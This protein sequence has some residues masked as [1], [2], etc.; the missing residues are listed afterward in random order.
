MLFGMTRVVVIVSTRLIRIH[1]LRLISVV[2]LSLTAVFPRICTDIVVV[3]A[4]FFDATPVVPVVVVPGTVS[5][6]TRAN[7]HLRFVL[8]ALVT[9]NEIGNLGN[10]T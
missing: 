10:L 8:I 1:V 6:G 7:W 3:A 2:V 4:K 5:I 9:L